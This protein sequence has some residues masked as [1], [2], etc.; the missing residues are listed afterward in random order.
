MLVLTLLVLL[1]FGRFL[2][3]D[4]SSGVGKC[5]ASRTAFPGRTKPPTGALSICYLGVRLS[6]E[7]QF[8]AYLRCTVNSLGFAEIASI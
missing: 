4:V 8:P 6:G 1:L 3:T 5:W 2:R 7:V